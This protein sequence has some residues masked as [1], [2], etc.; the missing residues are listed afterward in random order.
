[1]HMIGKWFVA[2]CLA[3]AGLVSVPGFAAEPA[4]IA[5][6]VKP[7]DIPY[8]KFTLANGLTVI[9]H[10][11]RK[12][13]IV[14][15]SIWYK[16]GSKNEPKGKTGYAHLFE[17]IMF[18]GSQQAPLDY[19]HYL[20]QLGAT[21]DNGSTWLDRTNY[22][23]TVPRAGLD[24]A[25]FLES[26]RMGYL[27]GAL[28]QEKLTNQIGVVQNEKRQ[29][30][31]QPYGLVG[32]KQTEMLFPATHPYGHST[33]GSM[34]DLEA[35]SLDDMR[36]WF[37]GHYGPNNA[38]LV[39]AGDIDADEAKPLV[40]KWFGAL[41]RGPEV[42]PLDPPVPTLDAPKSLVMHD[43]VPTTR[44]YR[45]WVL[46]GLNDPDYLAVDVGAAVLGGLA[47][48]RLDNI[49]VRNEQKAVAVTA[50]TLPFVNASIMESYV[51]VKPGEDVDEV[52]ARFDAIIADLIANGPTED[53]VRRVVTREVAGK[54]AGLEQVGGFGGKAVTLAQSE[55]YSND[56]AAYKVELE[57]LAT[58]TPKTVQ[59]ALQKWLTRPAVKIRVEP[60]KREAA[61][62]PEPAT[63][64]AAK[65]AGDDDGAI[66][67][68]LDPGDADR[69]AMPLPDSVPEL[70]FPTVE[71]ASLS[72]GI[73]VHFARR[74]AVPLVRVAIDFDAGYAADPKDK[75]GITS[76]MAA[77]LDEGTQ[78]L[79]AVGFAEAQERLGASISASA[80]LDRTSIEMQAMKANLGA[81]L[82]LLADTVRRP[83]FDTGA[84]ERVRVQQLT[85]IKAEATRPQ[86]LALRALPPL[87]YGQDHPYGVPFTGTGSADVVAGLQRD[88]L[89]AFFSQWIRP[90]RAEIFVVGDTSLDEILPMLEARFGKWPSNRMALLQKNFDTPS[91]PTQNRIIV[92]DRPNSPQSLILAGEAL[93]VKGTDD[94]FALRAA[95]QVLGGDFLSRMNTD[96]RETK[97]WSYGVSSVLQRPQNRIA[98]FILAP[99]QTDQTGPSVQALID[100]LK[101]ITGDKGVTQAELDRIVRNNVL[102]LAGNY[103]RAT[104]VLGQ[105]EADRLYDRPSD[106]VD[107]LASR[108]R[109]L[110]TDELDKAI[111]GAI[112]PA[113]LTWLIVGDAA[114][115]RAQIDA[116]GL[117]VEYGSASVTGKA[118]PDGEESVE[119]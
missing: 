85:R 22:F 5:E 50:Y 1:M 82:D 13:P 11:D 32:Y 96:L 89:T 79:D 103:E 55:L 4:P 57:R 12:A 37:T 116:L 60:G 25:L 101:G 84:L 87:L 43:D 40:E 90:E 53:E 54:V 27:L 59:A 72:N 36:G 88:D 46:P 47:S 28:T 115:I 91:P 111:S 86:A 75:L 9:V 93:D 108:Y 26:D 105:M 114:K 24:G 102:E 20:Q 119:E 21:D 106:Y 92:I 16:V 110:T 33:I 3:T 66:A 65:P 38:V 34:A 44:I 73:K 109:S 98:Y 15:V 45:N 14:A 95:N 80:S 104:A 70:D 23:E 49:L 56:P 63:A 74:D 107:T 19:F 29:S 7:V 117:P 69:S 64:T 42:A 61:E 83:A 51:D 2:L 118:E 94:L 17:H 78:S 10:E 48:S 35:A 58:M 39:L 18:N 67:M 113:G 71:Q 68:A 81:S 62:E 99:V 52:A 41:P 76:F 97:G 77:M 8:S 31:N 30:D 100:Q 112:D 6:L